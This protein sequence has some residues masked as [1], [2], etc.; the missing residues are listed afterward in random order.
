MLR[1]IGVVFFLGFLGLAGCGIHPSAIE[2]ARHP[3]QRLRTEI[4]AVLRDP[5]FANAYWGVEIQ[6]LKN[7][8][9][10]YRRNV[11]KS[12]RP[13]S[14][15]KLFTTGTA[16]VKLGPDFTYATRVFRTGQISRGILHG[17]L[18]VRGSG[19]PT[20]TGRFH[21]GNML[22][23][24]QD[25]ADS[26]KSQ[27]IQRIEGRIVGDDNAF[28]DEIMGEGWAWDYQSDWYA[29]QISALSFNDNCV[30]ILFTPG[31]SVGDTV[32]FRLE[33][34]THYVRVINQVVTAPK[35]QAKGV[36]FHRERGKNIVRITGSIEIGTPEKRDWFSVENPTLYAV[37]VF[38]E[39]LQN[40]GIS[41]T[42]P[43]VDIDSL[44]HYS[45]EANDS[46]CVA[47]YQSPDLAQIV[48][49]INK[50]SQ[51]LYA[52]LLLRTLG[53]VYRNDGSASGGIAVVKDFLSGI[54]IDP[55]RVAM[56]DGSGLSHLDM[57][58]PD[59][60]VLLLRALYR[61]AVRD[62]FLDSLPIAGV[63]G[64]LKNRMK[65]TAAEAN[66][67][68]KTGYISNTRSLSGFVTTRDG[69]LLSF[70][71][72]V[73]NYLVPTSRANFVQDWICERLAN[74]SRNSQAE[75]R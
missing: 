61:S 66:V 65:G 6:S 74:F 24:F 53:K 3:V 2:Q 30:D 1:K 50:V 70:S 12:F 28:A 16:L 4:N 34:P 49:A 19:D 36:F 55:N 5:A 13:A 27:G 46:L 8:Q 7:G 15:L 33:P 67:R 25:W 26:L 14:N 20:I 22:S 71:I 58:T 44:K 31:K 42:G 18:V 68:A 73:N 60:M 35:H 10:V 23:V 75:G 11:H 37:T 45:Y 40:R 63:D 59:E 72:L 43:A 41:V 21:D 39:V 52:E 47:L 69:E 48:R 17:D 32:S 57:I 64:S 54:G 56:F 62:E 38:R 51:N 9:Y 29:A